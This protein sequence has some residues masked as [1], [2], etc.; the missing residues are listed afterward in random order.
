[1]AKHHA[2]DYETF[3][4]RLTASLRKAWEQARRQRAGESFYLYGI[5]T[6]SDITDL[7]PLCNT[8]EEYR[9]YA[10]DSEPSTDKW[11]LCWSEDSELFRAGKEHTHAL[12]REL[13]RYVFEDHS[14]EPESAFLDRKRRLLRI[15]E[16]ALVQ[17]DE[18]GFFGT[19]TSTTSKIS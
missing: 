10:G 18:E 8:E 14:K 9:A 17:L 3:L 12:A 2:L 11:G 7:N 6:D 19:G 16:Q 13:N 1:M 4:S 5:E 15:F